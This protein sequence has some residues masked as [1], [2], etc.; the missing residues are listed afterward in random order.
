VLL[1][2]DTA[3]IAAMAMPAATAARMPREERAV[4]L[5][6]FGEIVTSSGLHPWLWWGRYQ[7]I[8]GAVKP[9]QGAE[10]GEFSPQKKATGFV[11]QQ[12][13]LPCF[14]ND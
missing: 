1:H 7:R 13:R 2:A 3:T 8:F 14:C 12:N 9:H 5:R 4:R 6:V 10:R 11:V